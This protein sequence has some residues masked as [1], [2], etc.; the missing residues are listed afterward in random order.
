[1]NWNTENVVDMSSMFERAISFNKRLFNKSLEKWAF[2][3]TQY[4]GKCIK[5]PTDIIRLIAEFAF[6][7][8]WNVKKVT[9]GDDMFKGAL[10]YKYKMLSLKN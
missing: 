9:N 4:L 6:G 3:E 1:L 10:S 5:L 2:V 7:G 8:S